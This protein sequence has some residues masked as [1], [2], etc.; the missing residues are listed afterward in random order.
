MENKNK[1]ELSGT[2]GRRWS[3]QEERIPGAKVHT[4]GITWLLLRFKPIEVPEML[5]VDWREAGEA[6]G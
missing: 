5:G 1:E 2:T 4:P 3:F 6:F